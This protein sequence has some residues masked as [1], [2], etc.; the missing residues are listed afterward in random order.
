MKSVNDMENLP[1]EGFS[2]VRSRQVVNVKM[3]C[4]IGGHDQ[5]SF[6]LGK[7]KI[8]Q[9]VEIRFLNNKILIDYTHQALILPLVELVKL[10]KYVI[11]L[12][13]EPV[14]KHET[15]IVFSKNN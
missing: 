3:K 6:T 1:T 4:C 11:L 10:Y 14:L 15:H 12:L 7:I 2:F 9:A 8:L 13:V 5:R